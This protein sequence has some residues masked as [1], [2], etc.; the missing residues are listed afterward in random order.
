MEVLRLNR[1]QGGL[2]LVDLSIKDKSLKI[3]WIKTLS[4]DENFANLAY[5]IINPTLNET[6]WRIN[7][8]PNDVDVVGCKNKFWTDVLYSW[9]EIN[10][11]NNVT[12]PE[13]QIIWYNSHIR[14]N[15]KPFLWKSNLESGLMYVGDLLD[16][17]EETSKGRKN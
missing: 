3:S 13:R 4:Q 16:F 1:F 14:Q 17:K 2:G 11:I 8:H 15:K 5:E 6:V 9:A 12:A 10:F 7:L